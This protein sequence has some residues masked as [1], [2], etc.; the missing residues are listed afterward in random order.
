MPLSYVV[1][2]VDHHS[3]LHKGDEPPKTY[4]RV[5]YLHHIDEDAQGSEESQVFKL[6]VFIHA[7]TDKNMQREV[8]WFELKT[9]V[10]VQ[11]HVYAHL[12]A[13]LSTPED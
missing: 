1:L 4:W 7:S 12:S 6:R 2:L 11:E 5:L 8:E 10:S 3:L 13:E 9:K